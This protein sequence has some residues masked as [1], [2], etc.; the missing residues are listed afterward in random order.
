MQARL[1]WGYPRLLR[2][3]VTPQTKGKTTPLKLNTKLPGYFII[4]SVLRSVASPFFGDMKNDRFIRWTTQ[5]SCPPDPG[6]LRGQICTTQ[7]LNGTWSRRCGYRERRGRISRLLLLLLYSRYRSWKVLAPQD[8]R[9]YEPSIRARLG[10]HST[11]TCGC[12]GRHARISRRAT[13][14]TT[15]ESV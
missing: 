14:L 11:P 5:R 12:R 1:R 4:R 9:V 13:R 10:D 8:T 2:R 7:G 3:G 6:A 15:K